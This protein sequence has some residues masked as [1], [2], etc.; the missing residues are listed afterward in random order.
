MEGCMPTQTSYI[1]IWLYFTAV[2]FRQTHS[3][4]CHDHV[5]LMCQPYQFANVLQPCC[6]ILLSSSTRP[7]FKLVLHAQNS[8][9]I[10]CSP[11]C[12]AVVGIQARDCHQ[13]KS[14]SKNSNADSKSNGKGCGVLML[15]DCIKGWETH[16][17]TKYV[18]NNGSGQVASDIQQVGCIP[19][20]DRG[21]CKLQQCL[22]VH[23][24]G[25]SR[26]PEQQVSLVHY[27]T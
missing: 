13:L 14:S 22:H 4:T 8:G 12:G 25:E 5:H 7:V 20:K 21:E 24:G 17:I 2:P 16:G 15:R 26:H 10:V 19:A 3:I 1:D 18:Y 9:N 27:A 11:I 6:S 23:T